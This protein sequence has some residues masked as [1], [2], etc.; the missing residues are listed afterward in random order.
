[1]TR[2]AKKVSNIDVL[3]DLPWQ[4][5]FAFAAFIFAVMKWL[6]PAIFN[7]S[8]LKP[9]GGVVAVIAPFAGIFLLIITVITFTKRQAI[10]SKLLSK[11]NPFHA[12][13]NQTMPD[14]WSKVNVKWGSS[15]ESTQWGNPVFQGSKSIVKPTSWSPDLLNEIEWK[16]F[17][18]VCAAYYQEKGIRAEL[19]KL[20]AD[21]G[22]DIKLYQDESGHPTS[23][24]QCKAWSARQV[25]V[26]E[27]RELLGV[28]T[29]EKISKAFYMTSS[30]YSEDAKEF[31]Q[32]NRIT[33]IDG[34]MLLAMILRLSPEAQKRLL[35]LVTTGDYTTPSCPSCGI[36][37]IKRSSKR[38]EFWGCENFPRC[39]QMLNCKSE[40]RKM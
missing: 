39:R 6:I 38:G 26:K 3:L 36:K 24:V 29:H 33:L 30:V 9:L 5:N 23:L 28:M 15:K 19:T 25:G 4:I 8:V 17:E 34:A 10:S 2:K 14:D 35:M 7:S 27:V 18:D 13:K 37:M 16:L 40:Q 22:I 21:G 11:N 12:P 20:G 31:A 32:S 1:M